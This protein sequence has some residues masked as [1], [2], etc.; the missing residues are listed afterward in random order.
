MFL[1]PRLLLP[2]ISYALPACSCRHLAVRALDAFALYNIII[3]SLAFSVSAPSSYLHTSTLFEPPPQI[4]YFG[5]LYPSPPRHRS[6][7]WDSSTVWTVQ[8][9]LLTT[10]SVLTTF[11]F[12]PLM[13]RVTRLP[14]PNTLYIILT[15]I[16]TTLP[17]Y[18]TIV[19]NLFGIRAHCTVFR[20]ICSR[21]PTWVSVRSHVLLRFFVLLLS[22][23]LN[24]TY[25]A[26][27]S[28]VLHTSHGFN[29]PLPRFALSANCADHGVP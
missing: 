23:T 15:T 1:T 3:Y 25:L 27:V 6:Q 17:H 19:G 7:S 21:D 18:L 2:M 10:A 24:V 5:I 26:E 20:S 12:P 29:A 16:Y 11:I 14:G 28:S 4:D 8:L 22:P 9:R 13:E